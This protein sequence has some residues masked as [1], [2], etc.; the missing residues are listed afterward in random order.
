MSVKQ[1]TKRSR[2][3]KPQRAP[4]ASLGPFDDRQV[5]PFPTWC[6]LNNIS[7]RTG[8]RILSSGKGPVTVRLST[9][10][11]GVTYAANRAWQDSLA[12]VS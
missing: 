4:V 1:K 2:A 9:N 5:L 8:R 11:M 7:L 3:R 12:R 10:R 6:E